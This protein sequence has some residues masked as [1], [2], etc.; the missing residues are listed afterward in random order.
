MLRSLGCRKDRTHVMCDGLLCVV[1]CVH[2]LTQRGIVRW[3]GV[4]R[5][6]DTRQLELKDLTGLT[7]IS[8]F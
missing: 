2:T 4:G 1:S 6:R 5:G 8:Y 7:N 3:E